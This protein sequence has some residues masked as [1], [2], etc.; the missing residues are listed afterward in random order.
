MQN[1]PTCGWRGCCFA[2]AFT[3]LMAVRWRPSSWL[4]EPLQFPVNPRFA[5]HTSER[6]FEVVECSFAFT[7]HAQAGSWERYML[8]C[9]GCRGGVVRVLSRS[10]NAVSMRMLS[11]R[12]GSTL[13]IDEACSSTF[14]VRLGCWRPS[15]G[16][17][18]RCPGCQAPRGV[19]SLR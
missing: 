5:F 7:V 12:S 18:L 14:S 9:A 2:K 17:R 1:G 11:F 16:A 19:E 3:L 15:A 6:A 13:S 8:R 10:Q 4:K